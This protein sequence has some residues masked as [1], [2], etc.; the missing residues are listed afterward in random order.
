LHLSLPWFATEDPCNIAV[1]QSWFEF[2][3]L[4][5]QPFLGGQADFRDL[6]ALLTPLNDV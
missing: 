5:P 4:V 2:R 6:G 1:P 3:E